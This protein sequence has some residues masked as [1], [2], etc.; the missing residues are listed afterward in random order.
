MPWTLLQCDGR[1]DAFLKVV[2]VRAEVRL[3][4]H[5]RR[6]SIEGN[7]LRFPDTDS[8]GDGLFEL[9][10]AVGSDIYRNIFILILIY[11]NF[12]CKINLI[13]NY[14]LLNIKI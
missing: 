1:V 13:I 5:L 11:I 12:L 6:L 14:R 8:L 7:A 4:R 9:R 3:L 2:G 10:T